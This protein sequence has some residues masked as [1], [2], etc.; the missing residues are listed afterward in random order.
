MLAENVQSR[1]RIGTSSIIEAISQLPQTEHP[2]AEQDK[3][4]VDAWA[5]PGLLPNNA[6]GLFV[7]VHGQFLEGKPYSQH[8]KTFSSIDICRRQKGREVI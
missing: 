1:L 5:Q 3:F 7:S 4:V 8:F 2:I 6:T